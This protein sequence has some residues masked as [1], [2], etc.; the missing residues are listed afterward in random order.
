MAIIK[1]IW[2]P[3]ERWFGYM[4]ENG[5]PISQDNPELV[6]AVA[7]ASLPSSPAEPSST[8]RRWKYDVFLSFRGLDTRKGIVFEL[9]DVLHR[10]GIKTFKDDRDLEVGYAISPTLL[11]A[12]E[13]SRFA[14]VVLSEKYASSTWCLD[15]LAKICECMKDHNRILP[16]FYHVEPSDVRYRKKG[17]GEAFTKHETSGRYTSEKLQQWRDALKQV[18]SFSGWHTQNFK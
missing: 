1:W 8:A 4:V 18:A 13:E 2:T 3:V 11:A 10:R 5:E 14:I 16:L 6:D 17:F 7:S 9:Y 15:E 12:I